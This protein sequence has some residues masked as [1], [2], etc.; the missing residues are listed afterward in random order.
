MRRCA[1][2]VGLVLLAA[3]ACGGSGDAGLIEV[4]CSVGGDP[5]FPTSYLDGPTLTREEFV[6]TPLGQELEALF[7][8]GPWAAENGDWLSAEGF[9][10][11]SPSTVLAYREGLPFFWFSAES[12]GSCWP[13]LVS[14]D[15]IARRWQPVQPVDREATVLPIEVEGGGC[16]TGTDTEIT[17][18]VVSVEVVEA[19]DRVEIV[20]W[21]R[22]A[23][24][25]GA[26]DGV[27]VL[28]DAEARLDAPVGDRVL[29][30]AGVI[31][32]AAIRLELRGYLGVLDCPGYWQHSTADFFED[33]Q[34][35]PT[36]QEALALL[37]SDLGLPPGTAQ[38]ES[39]ATDEVVYLFTDGEGHRLGRVKVILWQTS[40]WLVAETEECG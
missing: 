36:A 17:T 26:C 1:A 3:T 8:G 14:G 38:V 20:A 32:A 29:L 7:V 22:R 27:G 6:A 16:V 21:T 33:A 24:S 5:R 34:G 12:G 18:E 23:G 15:L 37:T 19:A 35:S 40:G 11:L 31:P 2:L 30:D 9:T 25:F 28:M 13:V 10:L 4:A 39:E